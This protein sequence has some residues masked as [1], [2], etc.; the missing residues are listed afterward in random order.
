MIVDCDSTEEDVWEEP[1]VQADIM[2][3]EFVHGKPYTYLVLTSSKVKEVAKLNKEVCLFDIS[4]V[5]Q[6]FDCLMKDKQIKLPKG[7]KILLADEIKGLMSSRSY[8]IQVRFKGELDTTTNLRKNLVIPIQPRKF[9][10]RKV[11]SLSKL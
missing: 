6:I 7:H 1:K 10:I 5:D 9:M 8:N 11:K 3:A 4:K 2:A